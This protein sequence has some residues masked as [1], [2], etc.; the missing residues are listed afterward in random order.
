MVES[1]KMKLSFTN[2][3]RIYVLFILFCNNNSNSNSN[4][5]NNNNNNNNNKSPVSTRW[6]FYW[7]HH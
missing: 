1:N 7:I 5:N 2:L 3:D 4:S 6:F